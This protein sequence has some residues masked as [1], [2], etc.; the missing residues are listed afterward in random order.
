MGSSFN[1]INNQLTA[2]QEF[3]VKSHV[4]KCMEC[5]KQVY[6]FN[7][8]RDNF[9]DIWETWS[10]KHHSIE[11]LRVKLNTSLVD[12]KGEPA[13][14]EKVKEWL[15]NFYKNTDLVLDIALERN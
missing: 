15:K 9:D 8:I 12:M 2:E 1:Y 4:A 10:V 5:G 13:L 3:K 7:K 6:N 11:K 14:V